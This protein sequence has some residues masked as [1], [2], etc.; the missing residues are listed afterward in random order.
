MFKQL[1]ANTVWQNCA[2]G[3]V[4]RSKSKNING[5]NQSFHQITLLFSRV[6]TIMTV[7]QSPEAGGATVWPY[8]RISVFPEKGSAAYWRN[9]FTDDTNDGFTRHKACPVSFK[10][11][12][13][14]STSCIL[15][16]VIKKCNHSLSLRFCTVKSGLKTSGLVIMHSGTSKTARLSLRCHLTQF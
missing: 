15:V 7:L 4:I 6:A 9:S 10:Y 1:E 14:R 2:L 12:K 16:I 8:A 13:E 3:R 5:S 11:F